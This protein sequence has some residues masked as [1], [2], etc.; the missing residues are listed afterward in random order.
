MFEHLY[1][2]TCRNQTFNLFYP[3]LDKVV[4]KIVV[5]L[6]PYEALQ[7]DDLGFKK[8]ERMKILEEWVSDVERRCG[9]GDQHFKHS[10]E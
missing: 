10:K 5:G 7:S 6:Y 1:L 9:G 3:L 2:Q 8:G 4:G